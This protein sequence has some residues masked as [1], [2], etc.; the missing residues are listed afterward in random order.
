[1]SVVIQ[2]LEVHLIIH[3]SESPTSR[4]RCLTDRA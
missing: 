3:D 4:S 2:N 1:L